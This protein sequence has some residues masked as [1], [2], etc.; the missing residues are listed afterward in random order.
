MKKS[1]RYKEIKIM[2]YEYEL[3]QY[4]L[5]QLKESIDDKN[6]IDIL[7]ELILKLNN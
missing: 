7:D 6:V 5:Q 1:K 3:I 4:A 2:N